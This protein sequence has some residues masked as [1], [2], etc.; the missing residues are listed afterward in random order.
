LSRRNEPDSAPLP[1]GRPGP[2]GAPSVV[3]REGDAFVL[4]EGFRETLIAPLLAAP[5][6]ARC[7][8]SLLGAPL[9][10]ACA[11][12]CKDVAL[13]MDALR[14]SAQLVAIRARALRARLMALCTALARVGAPPV[15]I[16]GLAT[17]LT[18][19]AK[20]YLRL[21]PDADLLF[22]EGDLA[23]AAWALGAWRFESR[24]DLCET[25]RWG[26][27]TEASF[28]PVAP[29]DGAFL[30]DVHRLVDDPPASEGL[31][32]EA[33]FARSQRIETDAGILFAPA[34]AHSFCILALHAF[35]DRYEPRGLKS[36]VD[37]ALLIAIEGGRIDWDEVERCA[38]AGRFVGRVVFYR[39]L[40]AALGIALPTRPFAQNRLSWA[41]R[42]LLA[43]VTAGYR[44]PRRMAQP[45][46]R[47]LAF[48]LALLDSPVESLRLNARR[49][50][51]LIAPRG[52][53]LPGL[54][55]A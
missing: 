41:G 3:R 10:Y 2:D 47:K 49:L 30:V 24:P 37:A 43:H 28:A 50:S 26:A 34:P 13:D 19:Y 40:L 14:A 53:L 51:G 52:H 15:A 42:R 6:S 27:L 11:Q 29:P 23:A 5:E 17:S 25:R 4:P 7:A 20:P 31:T 32:T 18:L 55:A 22:R 44:R 38:R 21:L 35:R 1:Q 36:L 54:P 8:I 46:S 33:V 45:D 12:A 39:E 48:E 9:V 16:K